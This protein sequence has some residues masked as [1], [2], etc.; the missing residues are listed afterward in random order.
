MEYMKVDGTS[1]DYPLQNISRITKMARFPGAMGVPSQIVP[2]GMGLTDMEFQ[3]HCIETEA[4]SAVLRAFIAQS[5]QL[6]WDKEGLISELRKELRV[7]D[8]EHRE[9]LLKV[10]SDDSIRMIR[11]WR[12]GTTSQ[13]EMLSDTTN[14]PGLVPISTGLVSRKKLKTAHIAMPSPPQAPPYLCQAQPSPTAF[15][16]S[17]SIHFIRD[18]QCGNDPAVFSAQG[19]VG[20]CLKSVALNKQAQ[21]VGKGRAS[22]GVQ[23][24]KGFLSSG[25]DSVKKGSDII[26]IR[27]TEIIICEVLVKGVESS[28]QG[29]TSSSKWYLWWPTKCRVTMQL[30]HIFSGQLVLLPTKCWM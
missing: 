14:A 24:K 1:N 4:Y 17:L 28:D 20:Q 3:I 23:S 2:C 19:S 12:S 10:D 5:E 15:P 16:S 8:V 9:I 11:D 6:S 21:T 27:P 25:L 29:G 13:Q 26:E 7:S 18:D 30:H 22:L